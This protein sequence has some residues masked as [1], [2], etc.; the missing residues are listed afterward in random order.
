MFFEK[1]DLRTYVVTVLKFLN[2]VFT[3]WP[4]G[5]GKFF[6]LYKSCMHAAEKVS[7][8]TQGSNCSLV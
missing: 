2:S 8:I 6:I 5:C 4:A 3:P 7:F 1:L